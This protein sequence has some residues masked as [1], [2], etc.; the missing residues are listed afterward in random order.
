MD[1]KYYSDGILNFLRSPRIDSKKY[2]PPVY[3]A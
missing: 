1:S 2:I 3:V